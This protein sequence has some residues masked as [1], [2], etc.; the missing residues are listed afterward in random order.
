MLVNGV[1]SQLPVFLTGASV[2]RDGNMLNIA[3][4]NGVSFLCDVTHDICR[5]EV[6]G[7][8]FG[9]TGG[10]LGTYNNEPVDDLS[11]PNGQRMTSLT[12]FTSSWSLGGNC[13]SNAV[14]PVA[15][16][17]EAACQELFN[18]TRSPFRSC[19]TLVSME[20]MVSMG[21]C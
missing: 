11:A 3:T 5:L 13:H 15:G 16:K 8:Q 10:L 20:I 21:L 18:N 14:E 19:Y 6:P 4:T 9:K 1:I 2:R 17:P 7:W 12:D